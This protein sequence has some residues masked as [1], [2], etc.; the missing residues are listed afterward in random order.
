MM[1][2]TGDGSMIH[3]Q[4]TVTADHEGGTVS[5]TAT[6]DVDVLHPGIDL[7]KTATP[8]AGPAG[9]LIV[10]TYAVTNTGDTPL[11]EVSVDDDR[12]NHIGDIATLAVGAT[13]ERTAEITLAPPRSPTRA[14]PRRGPP[15]QVRGGTGHRHGD[16]GLAGGRRWR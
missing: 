9:T 5:D 10:Y 1:V 3:N 13:V 2:T 15:G 4:A 16:R 14:L 7:E 12:L 8:T 6:H 11:F